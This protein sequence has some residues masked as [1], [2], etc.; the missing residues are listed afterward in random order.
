MAAREG[1]LAGLER[2]LAE[3]VVTWADGGG[4]VGAARRPVVGG[5]KVARYLLGALAKAGDVPDLLVSEVNGEA[6]VLAVQGPSGRGPGLVGVMVPEVGDGVIIGIRIAAN[7]D[8]LGFASFQLLRLS[9]SA[10][11][12]GS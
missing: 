9:H 8:K 6:A 5:A 12:S 10:W 4:R 2:L 3:D 7:P 1:D 11:S